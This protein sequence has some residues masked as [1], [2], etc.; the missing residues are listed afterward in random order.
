MEKPM[1]LPLH[2]QARKELPLYDGTWGYFPDSL[3]AMAHVSYVGNNQHNPGEPLHWARNK[4]TDQFNT[5]MRHI[6]DHKQGAR[7][8]TD[9]CRHLAKA[10]WRI[11]AAM[12][13][14][15]EVERVENSGPRSDVQQQQ[16]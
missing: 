15:I 4:S 12:Q 10:M 5:A 2:D 14:D 7:Y 8:D 9:G 13:L 11:A 16:R 1:P 3:I 6:L